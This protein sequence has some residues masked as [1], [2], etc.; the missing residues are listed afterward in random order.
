[1]ARVA[2]VEEERADDRRP[3]RGPVAG[4]HHARA[5]QAERDTNART[6]RPEADSPWH[7]E[8]PA[9]ERA[10]KRGERARELRRIP[11][12][13]LGDERGLLRV[14]GHEASAPEEPIA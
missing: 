12:E 13:A 7:P 4:R 2:V 1:M 10:T 8:E 5:A 6:E 9:E 14:V 11:R 3:H